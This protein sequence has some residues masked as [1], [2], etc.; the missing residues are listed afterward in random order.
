MSGVQTENA[1]D[2]GGTLN[3][4]WTDP[5]DWMDYN[6]NVSAAGNTTLNFRFAAPNAGAQIQIRNSSGTVLATVTFPSTGGWQTWQTTGTSV[7]LPAGVQTLRI[8][9]ATGGWNLNWFEMVTSASTTTTTVTKEAAAFEI[10]RS[11]DPEGN[12]ILAGTVPATQTAF[13][14][15]GLLANSVFY[16]KVKAVNDGGASGFSN[17]DS[18]LTLNNNPVITA[19]PDQTVRFGTQ[20]QVNV[21]IVDADPGSLS[22]EVANLP[23]FGS[24]VPGGN[25]GV[26]SF[27]PS[28]ADVGTY[29]NIIVT[30]ADHNGGTSSTVFNLTV[31][32]NYKPVIAGVSSVTLREKE[33]ARINLSA[34]DQNA[35]DV[36]T[37]SFSGLP[38]FATVTTGTG[39]AQID[40]APGYADHGSYVVV[41][42][43]DDGHT[44]VDSTSFTITVN[45][46]DPSKTIYVNFTD[47]T[48]LAGAPW[49]NTGKEPAVNDNF[50]GLKDASGAATT[51]GIQLLTAWTGVNNLGANTGNNSGVFPDAVLRSS[52][53]T[54][55]TV[56]TIKVY[57]LA[58]LSKNSFRLIG[59]R[60]NPT[61]GV[62]T[63]FTIIGQTQSLNAANNAQNTVTFT[64]ITP[65]ADGSVTI[66]IAGAAGSTYGYLNGLVIQ[67]N[68]DD[69]TAPAAPRNLTAQMFSG[70]VRL[71]WVDAAYNETA[72]EVY[73]A[74]SEAG[75]YTL[76]NPGGNNAG[77]QVYD[78]A[79]VAGHTTY[80][81]R[82]RAVNSSGSSAN[83]TA[84]I[85]TPNTSPVLA[86]IANVS[87]NTQQVVDVPVSASDGPGE[88]ITLSVT[89]LPSFASF[90]D[91][92]NGTGVI[93]ISPGNTS[94]VFTN[95]TVTARD[96]NN[97]TS[98]QQFSITVVNANVTSVFINFNQTSPEGAPWNNMNTAPTAGAAIADLKDEANSSTGMS[99]SLLD[100]WTAQTATGYTTGNNSGLYPDNVMVNSYYYNANNVARRIQLGGLSNSK[101]YNLIF[102]ASRNNNATSLVTRYSAGGQSAELQ[103]A[104]NTS[105]TVKI[106]DISPDENGQILITALAT[107]G[108]NAYIG[109]LVV[110]SYTPNLVNPVAPANLTA[111]GISK[112]K[113]L[114]KWGSVANTGYELWRSA[115]VNGTYT[116]I[117]DIGTNV[118]T[119]T[120]AGLA[121]A[122]V[123]YYKVKALLNSNTSPYSNYAG[124]STVAYHLNINMNDGTVNAPAQPGNWNNTNALIAD[125]FI[126]PN[127]VNDLGQS[128]G[129]NF[130]VL[131]S[132]SG[133]NYYGATTG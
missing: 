97:A 38:S 127:M 94:G 61:V 120:D 90:T 39:T 52:Y 30:V 47:G 88:V 19:I 28:L 33:T 107:V 101:K 116:K 23:A 56:R 133:F 7:N 45:D 83:A 95:I 67:S 58:P 55:N 6:V 131:K 68:Y 81:Y 10:Y 69:G 34:S 126:L 128:T 3:V 104:N 2:A 22:I 78:D 80:F 89:G 119:Y 29:N 91:N 63:N 121:A 57:G 114:L 53:Y 105:N 12:Y 14:N 18:A 124:A 92:G 36:L 75:P 111:A 35:G 15:E 9:A 49:N 73:R 77:L 74:A 27:N 132:F 110:E 125:G 72:Y 106:S 31:N 85:T 8:Y 108:P 103:V 20:L 117:A 41:A 51:I 65:A 62:V 98:T 71:S 113:I 4:G 64:N 130:T 37:W 123:Y 99:I 93:H 112:D 25:G 44:G 21:N 102:F 82:V 122:S 79:T 26:L 87:M 42:K 1:A 96:G 32:G 66:G 118:T 60:A 115:S 129:I 17:R 84:T 109:S 86:P 11:A 46:V 24:F 40:L 43:V 16:Y 13:Q 48:Y 5:G 70:K 54:N 59:S 50:A 76:L 100:S